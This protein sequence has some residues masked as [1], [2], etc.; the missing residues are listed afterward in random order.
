MNWISFCCQ[1][2]SIHSALF[3]AEK[4]LSP[5]ILNPRLEA[6]VLLAET[7]QKDRIYLKKNP[8]NFLSFFQKVRFLRNIFLRKKHVPIAYIFHQKSWGGMNIFV[9]KHVL[10]PRDETE[11]LCE[12]IFRKKRSKIPEKILDIG[13]GSGCITCAMAK[14]YNSATVLGIDISKKALQV[15]QK[16]KKFLGFSNI[17][18]LHS[19]MLQK[20]PEKSFFDIIIANL[21]YVP[22]SISVSLEVQKEPKNAVFSED[23][24]LFHIQKLADQIHQKQIGFEELW[25]EFLPTQYS[26]IQKIFSGFRVTPYTDVGGAVFFACVEKR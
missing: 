2:V 13:T 12:H 23:S 5:A 18:L 4:F 24:G 26:D 25:L 8:R 6:E 22:L 7:L 21:P 14:N 17:S 3:F 15:A 10:I 11:I 20:I 16:N 19:D 9:N 1:K